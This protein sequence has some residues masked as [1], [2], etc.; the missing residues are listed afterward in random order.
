MIKKVLT[1]CQSSRS[2]MMRYENIEDHVKG[3][4]ESLKRKHL[5]VTLDGLIV[6]ASLG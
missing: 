1:W 2:S 5:Q 4:L 3:C 6:Q